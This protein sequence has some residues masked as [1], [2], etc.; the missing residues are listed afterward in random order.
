MDWVSEIGFLLSE[1]KIF[2]ETSAVLLKVHLEKLAKIEEKPCSTCIQ[3][4]ILN[5]GHF[6][7]PT[8][9]NPVQYYTHTGPPTELILNSLRIDKHSKNQLCNYKTIQCCLMCL[10]N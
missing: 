8:F 6:Q 2:D 10:K 9:E 4:V 7:N 1:I 3:P 5:Q